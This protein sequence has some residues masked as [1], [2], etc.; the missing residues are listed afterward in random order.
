MRLKGRRALVTGAANGI[1]LACAQEMAREG[2]DVALVDLDAA[3]VKRAAE[4]IEIGR[5]HV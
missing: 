1:G 2:A 3:G 5:A 4:A